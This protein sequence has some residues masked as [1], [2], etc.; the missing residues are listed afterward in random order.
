[1]RIAYLDCFAGISGDMFLGALIRRRSRPKGPPRSHRRHEPRRNPPDRNSRPQRHLFH[2]GPRSRERRDRRCSRDRT[3]PSSRSQPHA[4]TPPET[5]HLHK[6]AILTRTKNTTTATKSIITHARPLAHRH[7]QADP[8]RTIDRRSQTNRHP[9][10]RAARSLRSQDPQRSVEQLH[11][12]EVGAV[13]AIVDIVAAS[14]GI[15]ALGVT[16]WFCSPLNVGGG[17]VDCAHGRFPVPAPATAA[18]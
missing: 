17:M 3:A 9:R 18:C 14:A 5:Q 1:M 15:H 7:P 16:R 8:I 4:S 2:Q 13:D 10:L 6:P 12:H 11:F